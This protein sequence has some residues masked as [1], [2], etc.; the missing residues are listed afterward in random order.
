MKIAVVAY[1]MEGDRTGVGRYLDGL[2]SGIA[3][4]DHD[5][6]WQ[7]YFKGEPFEHSLWSDD[8][9]TASR[10]TFQPFFDRRPTA[11]P[12]LWE[13][14]R[15]PRLLRRDR[16][17]AVFSP[18]YSLPHTAGAPGVVTVHDLS[19]ELLPGD[20]SR[21]ERWRRRLLARRA[22]R[23]ARRVLTDT[24]EI[25]R[26]LIRCYRLAPGKIGVV[27]LG[28]DEKFL[29]PAESGTSD[30]DLLAPYGIHPPYLLQVGSM[31]E[32]RHVDLVIA[33]FTEVA[34]EH[35]DLTLVLAGRNRLRSSGDLERWIHAS[36]LGERIVVAGYLEEEALP[37]LY[38]LAT[39]SFYLS[40]YEGYGLPPLESLA[41]GTPPV[42]SRG[43][44]LDE[45]WPDYPYR[46]LTLDR[47]GV[48]KVTTTALEL[49]DERLRVAREGQERMA[50]L[51]WR[52][53]AELFLDQMRSL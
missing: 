11:R 23:R 6:H 19:F 18:A 13:Q 26:D 2:L 28:L 20:F 32:R 43:L 27:P 35:P 24:E 22:V 3:R 14:L 16:P 1:E 44:A 47:A 17:D 4:C 25:K 29:K 46:A 53:A 42:V 41:A 36:G 49:Q 33:A 48:L 15:L 30:V 10:P 12:I 40:S 37:A 9:G 39:L 7:L 34:A 21:K 51:D 8:E 45:L 50:R 38:R 52:H 5:W 31:L